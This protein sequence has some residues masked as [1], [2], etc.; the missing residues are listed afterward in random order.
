MKYL[1]VYHSAPRPMSPEA[2]GEMQ[3]LIEESFK[4]GALVLTGGI[5]PV[6]NGGARVRA[7][8]GRI[9]VDG[10]YTE[11]KELTG[12]FAILQANS[13]EE[14]IGLTTRFLKV[15]GDGECELHQIDEPGREN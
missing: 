13:R 3:K 5:Q 8:G 10:P 14:A 11:T 2:M 15:V 4:S 1:S 12:G 6:K 7:S 9:T